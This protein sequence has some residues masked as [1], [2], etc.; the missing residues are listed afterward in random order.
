MN[1]I[2]FSHSFLCLFVSKGYLVGKQEIGVNTGILKTLNN[3]II[4]R[5]GSS[6]NDP[7]SLKHRKTTHIF[8][9]STPRI[10][11]F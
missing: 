6:V 2:L 1:L 8:L 7:L 3:D 10:N 9:P 4:H 11:N 5:Y